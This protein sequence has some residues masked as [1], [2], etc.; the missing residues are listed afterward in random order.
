MFVQRA[1][2]LGLDF[3]GG[4]ALTIDFQDR[5]SQTSL[6]QSLLKLGHGESVI[7]ELGSGS[8]LIRMRQ[9][10]DAVGQGPSEKE[11]IQ[12]ALQEEF[13]SI[14]SAN[15][16]SISPVVA[17]ETVRNAIIAVIVAAMGVLIYVTWAFRRMNNPFRL[18]ISAI[19]TLL[20]D[21]AMVVGLFS[22]LGKALNFEINAMF[23][24][25]VLAVV[26]YSVNDTIVVFDRIRENAIK[27]T[28][29]NLENLVNLSL[30][31]TV[32]RSL[33]TSLT[34]IFVILS[35]LF[36]GG[37]TIRGFLVVLLSGFIVGTYSSIFI[38][39]Q[40]LI[41]WDKH[42]WTKVFRPRK[43]NSSAVAPGQTEN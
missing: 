32:T 15:L 28:A 10:K 14:R 17:S 25:G 3:T 24:T 22:I 7:Q 29:D 18:G 34:T 23:V 37:P 27:D 39:P 21:V 13:G 12:N 1:F 43:S 19:I 20:H 42:E 33:N 38:A 16:S 36:I 2:R 4:S 6:R 11:T 35:L 26:G 5:V 31:Q 8:F 9:L 41:V 40:L 30:T